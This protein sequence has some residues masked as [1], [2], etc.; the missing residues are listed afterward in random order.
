MSD[1]KSA[2][3]VA[4]W[5]R[6][7]S[8]QEHFFHPVRLGRCA[9]NVFFLRHLRPLLT[10]QTDFLELGCG[11]ASL[12]RRL[13]SCI[14]S[15]TGADYASSAITEARRM[16]VDAPNMNFLQADLFDLPTTHLY[17]IVWSQ[18]LLEHFGDPKGALKKHMAL[19][20]P[21]GVVVV[22]VPWKY[23]YMTLWYAFTRPKAL[24]R[25]WPWIDQD[26]HTSRTLK[27]VTEGIDEMPF[28]IVWCKPMSPAL[29]G[30]ITLCIRMLPTPNAPSSDE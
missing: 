24:R 10:R 22:S 7:W 17:D 15:Y 13:A 16:H 2:N 12:G 26:F 29:L 9:Y 25:F 8:A 23:S 30:I 20:K 5:E 21:G 28:E 19:C 6:V 27:F 4:D 11:T 14:S 18:G 1:M 3:L